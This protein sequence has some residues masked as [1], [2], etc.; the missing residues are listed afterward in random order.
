MRIKSLSLA[1]RR[2]QCDAISVCLGFSSSFVASPTELSTF[3]RSSVW[4]AWKSRQGVSTPSTHRRVVLPTPELLVTE[5]SSSSSFTFF[6]CRCTKSTTSSAHVDELAR[7]FRRKINWFFS[8]AD[9]LLS[10]QWPAQ[11][12]VKWASVFYAIKDKRVFLEFPYGREKVELC[13]VCG[14]F[15]KVWREFFFFFHFPDR[16]RECVGG[17]FRR[18]T[19]ESIN[20]I[21]GNRAMFSS[22]DVIGSLRWYFVCVIF[23]NRVQRRSH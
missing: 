13:I 12:N 10:G 22:F 9:S 19:R 5:L 14:A 7:S 21:D 16:H 18:C 1:R 4:G 8:L 23:V 2:I 15:P 3:L 11:W 6:F 17:S 20:D